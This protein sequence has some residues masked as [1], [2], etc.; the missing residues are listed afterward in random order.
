MLAAAEGVAFRRVQT[1]RSKGGLAGR[2]KSPWLLGLRGT[3][4]VSL[5]RHQLPIEAPDRE[6]C[7]SIPKVEHA[8]FSGSIRAGAD[9]DLA[10]AAAGRTVPAL[11]WLLPA[12]ASGRCLRLPS[13][14][15]PAGSRA[16]SAGR[17]PPMYFPFVGCRRAFR[18]GR[19]HRAS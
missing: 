17:I 12:V 13:I 3:G 9:R 18:P 6:A 4:T 2:G 19:G 14:C 16:G 10:G 11:G 15:A 1:V 7:G 5:L 8:E